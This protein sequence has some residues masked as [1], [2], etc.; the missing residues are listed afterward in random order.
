M[1][2]TVE[3]IH[4]RLTVDPASG[5]KITGLQHVPTGRQWL[6][7]NPHLE[8]KP[9]VY[10]ASYVESLDSGGWDEIFPSVTPCRI[11]SLEIPDHGDLVS[12]PW[13]VLDTSPLSLEMAVTTRFSPCRFTRVLR[14]EGRTLK[15]EYRLENLGTESI[16]YLWCAH[17]LISIEPGMTIALP[18]GLPMRTNGGAAFRW[19]H[20]PELPPLDII[21]DPCS[22]GFEPFAAKLFTAGGSVS[23]I[24]LTTAD[25]RDQLRVSWNTEHAPFLGLWLNCGAWSGCGSAPYFNLGIEPATAPF[26]SL[27][28]AILNGG[29]RLIGPGACVAWSLDLTVSGQCP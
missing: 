24:T 21:Q 22:P 25:G 29:Y 28:D 15:V 3:N 8:Q 7:A 10:A 23:E 5:G 6:W 12:L 17:P 11:G 4:L 20:A 14:L 2:L 16:P 18:E 19:P 13:E 27:E 9:G 26:D 1:P